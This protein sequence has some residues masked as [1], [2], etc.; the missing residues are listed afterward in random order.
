MSHLFRTFI[1]Y[2]QE[3]IIWDTDRFPIQTPTAPALLLNRKLTEDNTK[4]LARESWIDPKGHWRQQ[5]S[6]TKENN[7]VSAIKRIRLTQ[8]LKATVS[9]V[10]QLQSDFMFRP[11]PRQVSRSLTNK[12][13]KCTL[14]SNTDIPEVSVT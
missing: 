5:S 7:R 3:S 9:D 4:Q 10:G 2:W 13:E 1:Y 14:C 11:F 12:I 6:Y 8:V